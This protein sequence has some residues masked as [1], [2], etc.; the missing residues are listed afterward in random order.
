MGRKSQIIIAIALVSAELSSPA[1][2]DTKAG[3]DAWTAGDYAGAVKI[4]QD[5]AAR[6]D[7]DAMFN[8]GQAYRMGQGVAKDM[9]MAEQ[10]YGRASS[11]GH[12]QA[13]DNYGLLMF[14]RGER[15]KAL[16]FVRAAADR[17]DPRAQYFLGI[18]HFNGELVAKD[19]VRAYALVSL[20]QQ[21]GIVPA[22]VA[23]QQMD[24]NVP[25]EQR[26]QAAALA[27]ELDSQAQATRAR[28]LAA[29]DLSG[30]VP[31]NAQAAA[32]PPR[33][34]RAPTIAAAED[35]IERARRVAGTDSPATA[36]ADY[37]RPAVTAPRPVSSATAAPQTV[38]PAATIAATPKPT[39]PPA[40]TP[41]VASAIGLWRVQLGAF[42][43]A[44]N[45]N[46]MWTKLKSRPE[47]AGHQRFDVKAGAVTKLQ[48]GGFA[49]QA[50]AQ[51]ACAKL[52]AAGF[53]CLAVKG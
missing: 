3:V 31:G 38:R 46:A 41:A 45:A 36:G 25:I 51:A 37:A 9:A 39:S 52:Q 26:Q 19:Y 48:A 43:V 16:P 18:L 14:Q 13:S 24:E 40:Q 27:I 47:L 22:R 21:Q 20:A 50:A 35:P 44:A 2:A 32:L 12:L 8:L 15:A 17:G 49:S 4:W 1:L 34:V 29:I 23:L 7:A 53:T 11:L 6:G 33:P 5:D 30:Q 42:G 28:Q 10:M